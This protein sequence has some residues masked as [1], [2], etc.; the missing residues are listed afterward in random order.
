MLVAASAAQGASFE[1]EL[2][3]GGMARVAKR[4]PALI[5]TAS[6]GSGTSNNHDDGNLN[7]GR[8]LAALG[9]QGR[10]RLTHDWSSA[11][12]KLEAVYFY[13]AVNAD[14]DTEFRPLG[15][16]ARE[17]AGR[18]AYLNE[19]Y[20]GTHGVRLGRQILRWSDSPWFGHSL[21]P[22]NPVS[23]SRRYQPGNG[24]AEAYVALPMLTA[25]AGP[26]QAFYQLGF[27]PTEPEAA[28]TFLSTNDY[29][30]PGAEFLELDTPFGSRVRRAADRRPGSGGQLGARVE[31]G[32]IGSARLVVAAQ[33]MRVHSREP[34]VSVNTGTL[35]GLTG[36]TA[37]DYASSG[38]Y[39]VEYP[40]DVTIAGGMLRFWPA[41][42][43]RIT[44][45]YSLRR[46]QPLQIDDDALV[47][48]GFAP[49]AAVAACTPDPASPLCSATLAQ[50]NL[51]PVI[52]AR[53]GITAANAAQMF[54]TEIRGYERFDVS[55]YAIGVVQG[56]PPLLG[57]A[58]GLLAAEAGGVHIHGFRDGW[59]DANVSPRPDASGARR[60]GL[61]TR[62]AWGYRLSARLDYAN[63]LGALR[64]SPSLT[65]IHDVRGNAPI[66][67]G[68]LLEHSRSLILGA[69]FALTRSL[70]GRLAYRNYLGKGHDSDRLTDRD[71]V[72]FSLT[73]KF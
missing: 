73:R 66:T 71:F 44:L 55:Q 29:Y 40:P 19:A 46:G 56:L 7:Y 15:R 54:S 65:W 32:E 63:L 37:P 34:L 50:L 47:G 5:G 18:N 12:L 61:A 45:E 58:G 59:L 48:A 31:S 68:T 24:L 62:S 42:A 69:D 53:G 35:G 2:S 49:A 36:T 14:G 41:R 20:A 13:D 17:R 57:A 10:S 22:V 38:S 26:L 23:A 21:A 6:G 72:S 64:V 60:I 4:D 39:F 43:T 27:E 9:V 52:A 67:L 25:R 33:L 51:N 70:G 3:V 8:G 30:S 1:H 11:E 28:G 16:E